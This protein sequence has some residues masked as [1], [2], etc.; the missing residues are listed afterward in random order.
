M[1]AHI[2]WYV[3][4]ATGIVAWVLATAAVLWGMAL[5][6]RALGSKPRAPWLLDLHRYLGGI[7]VFFVGGHVAA[8]VA[9]SY[10]EFDLSDIFLPMSSEWRPVPVALGIVAM[11]FLLAVEVTSLC[12]RWL[13]KRAWRGVH[14]TSYLVYLLASAHY[15]TA[16][17]DA[18]NPLSRIGVLVSGALIVFFLVYLSVGPGKAASVRSA[19]SAAA[20][21][22]TPPADRVHRV[23]RGQRDRRDQREPS[24]GARPQ[25]GAREQYDADVPVGSTAG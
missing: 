9:D 10:V 2:W 11:Y 21:S 25:D 6:T 5:S 1:S 16:G 4:R 19:R 17:S 14:L 13:S 23:Q 24:A 3:A 8:L 18:A 7:T 15:L 22:A 20:R 12:R